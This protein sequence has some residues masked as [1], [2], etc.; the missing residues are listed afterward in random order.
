MK[1]ELSIVIAAYNEEANIVPLYELIREMLEETKIIGEAIWVDDGSTD[2]TADAVK[3]LAELDSR[4]RYIGLSQNQGQSAALLA[5]IQAANG[6]ILAFL[7]ADLQNHPGDIPLLIA[8][9]REGYEMVCGWRKKR[10][11]HYISYTLP[12]RVGNVLIRML[13]KQQ[14]HDLGCGLKVCRAYTVKNLRYFR[15][16]HRY[17]PIVLGYSGAKIG[18]VVVRHYPRIH[19][20]S[21][22]SFLK[23]FRVIRELLYLR[24]V[25]KHSPIVRPENLPLPLQP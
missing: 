16:I 19:G 15:N 23:A 10:K 20:Q 3:T 17:L 18:E 24:F 2:G 14:I 5:G 21:K 25:Y 22:Y 8:K 6:H 12:S 7:D 9:L 1:P 4:V 13:F 11:D